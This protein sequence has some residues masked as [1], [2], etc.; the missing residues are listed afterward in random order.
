MKKTKPK[1]SSFDR[2]ARQSREQRVAGSSSSQSTCS[3]VERMRD[4]LIE[5]EANAWDG[6]PRRRSSDVGCMTA[7]KLID[8]ANAFLSAN[9]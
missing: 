2:I 5:W 4:A 9:N 1:E 8:E 3:L 7:C 6:D